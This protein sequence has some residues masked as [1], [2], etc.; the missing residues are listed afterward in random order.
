[1]D[2]KTKQ[3]IQLFSNGNRRVLSRVISLVENEDPGATAILKHFNS[4]MGRAHRVGITGPPGAGKSTLVNCLVQCFR[5]RDCSVAVLAVDPTS[6]F[7]GG[8]LLGDRIRMSGILL[9][10]DV[11]MRSM[12]SRGSTGGL[13]RTTSEVADVLDAFGFDVI[14]VETVGVGQL[15]LDVA[16]AVDTTVVVLVPEA[17]GN[18]QAMKAGLIEIA[19]IF[20]VNKAD[21]EGAE[22]QRQDIEE[23]LGLRPDSDPGQWKIPILKTVALF[24]KGVDQ[25][26]DSIVEHLSH[27]QERNQLAERRALQKK[28]KIIAIMKSMM[29]RKLWGN[30]RYESLLEELSRQCI[31]GSIDPFTAASSFL[32]RARVDD[33]EPVRY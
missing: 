25:L 1:M 18:V 4:R 14:I 5:S 15:E 28:R 30:H 22:H 26:T 16:G 3:L 17:G 19:D 8:A 10:Q 13:A 11:F 6:P 20:V 12:A 33:L 31:R 7:T 9:D 29:E 32:K 23:S 27:L 24:E 21:R 2:D